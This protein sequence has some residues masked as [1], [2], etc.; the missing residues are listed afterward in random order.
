MNNCIGASSLDGQE[1]SWKIKTGEGVQLGRVTA[2]K[3]WDGEKGSSRESLQADRPTD[4]FESRQAW[5]MADHVL[6]YPVRSSRIKP[7]L[8]KS[9]EL[10]RNGHGQIP[11]LVQSLAGD[12]LGRVW[13]GLDYCDRCWCATVGGCQLTVLPAAF[14]EEGS[15]GGAL[16]W[17]PQHPS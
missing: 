2:G 9:P 4:N 10:G 12:C 17:L 5:R 7:A 13:P 14:S 15:G 8:W 16:L 6:A 3:C 11:C 1:N